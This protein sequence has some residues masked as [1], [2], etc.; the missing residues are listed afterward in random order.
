MNIPFWILFGLIAGV[1]ANRLNPRPS[2]EGIVGAVIL[3]TLGAILGSFL[4]NIIFGIKLTGFSYNSF[5]I[6][7]LGSLFVLILPRLLNKY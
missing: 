4:G 1:V 3:G 2:E 6:A 7:I 5:L